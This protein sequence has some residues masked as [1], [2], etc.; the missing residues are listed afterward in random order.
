MVIKVKDVQ[1]MKLFSGAKI[2]LQ[3]L[4]TVYL[5]CLLLILIL[6]ELVV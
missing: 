6:Y 5:F 1:G 4:E 3:S 2:R